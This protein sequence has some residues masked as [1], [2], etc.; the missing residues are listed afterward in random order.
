MRK[1][2]EQIGP[3]VD[4]YSLYSFRAGDTTAAANARHPRSC[5]YKTWQ[6][7]IQNWTGISQRSP[8]QGYLVYVTS[9]ISTGFHEHSVH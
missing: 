6:V 7:E 3:Q 5:F 4:N 9:S 2:L 1:K 8:D